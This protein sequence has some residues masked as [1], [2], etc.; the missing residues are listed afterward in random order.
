M[1]VFVCVDDNFGITFNNRRQSRDSAVIDKIKE[2]RGEN[3][4]HIRPFSEKMLTGD[5]VVTLE[6]MLERCSKGDFCFV[7]D[8]DIAPYADK[9]STLVLFKWN[10]DYPFDKKLTM[11]LAGWIMEETFDFAGTSHEKI[12]CEVWTK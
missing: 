9:I 4:L 8:V 6:N 12:T 10:R 1:T 5:D 2:I 3:K 7:E 11:D